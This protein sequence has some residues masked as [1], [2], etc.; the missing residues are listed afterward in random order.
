MTTN[1]DTGHQLRFLYE[2]EGGVRAIFSSRVAD[3]TASRPDYPAPLFETLGSICKLSAGAVVADVGA[4]TGLL[5]L[6]LLQRGYQVTA[7]EPNASMRQAADYFLG[8]FPSYR[9]VEGYAESIPLEASS[10]DLITAAQAFHWFEIERARTECLRILRPEGQVALIWNDRV[11]DDPL[12]VQLD[13]IFAEFGGAKRAA[14]L[15]TA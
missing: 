10:V 5:T 13:A 9:S 14:L 3:Y 2:Q 4:G 6:G 11:L 8:K 1:T 15:I 7:I 12:H